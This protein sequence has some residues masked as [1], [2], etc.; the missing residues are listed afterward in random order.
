MERTVGGGHA[1]SG[2]TTRRPLLNIAR[3]TAVP[4]S[5][6]KEDSSYR[7]GKKTTTHTRAVAGNAV[8]G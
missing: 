6:E 2:S 1:S 4:I 7:R 8:R 5:K 3:T